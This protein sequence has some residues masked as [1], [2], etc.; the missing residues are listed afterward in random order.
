[1]ILLADELKLTLSLVR[2]N[3]FTT[4]MSAN[5]ST[6]VTELSRARPA[7]TIAFRSLILSS[8]PSNGSFATISHS[9]SIDKPVSNELMKA[10]KKGIHKK[11]T[12]LPAVRASLHASYMSCLISGLSSAIVSPTVT[13]RSTAKFTDCPTRPITRSVRSVDN[14]CGR[15][16]RCC[17][18]VE[19]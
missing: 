7:R 19:I 10:Y 2:S 18:S 1:M 3:C 5:R 4:T 17:T 9:R 13:N 12:I 16:D 15:S 11:K 14:E 8:R 6:R